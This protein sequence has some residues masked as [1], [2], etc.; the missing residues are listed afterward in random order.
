MHNDDVFLGLRNYSVL[1]DHQIKLQTALH[2]TQML[3]EQL[4]SVKVT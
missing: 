2:E 3:Q 4:N 1:L